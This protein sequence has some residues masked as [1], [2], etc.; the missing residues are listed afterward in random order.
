MSDLARH[1]AGTGEKMEPS[2]FGRQALIAAPA[3][4]RL[5]FSFLDRLCGGHVRCTYLGSLRRKTIIAGI[6]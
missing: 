3:P 6:A 4:P 1:E 5:L 2:Q